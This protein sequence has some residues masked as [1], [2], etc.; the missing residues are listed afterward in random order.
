M[1]QMNQEKQ[2]ASS[3]RRNPKKFWQFVNRK[4]KM[5]QEV[6]D[7]EDPQSGEIVTSDVEKANILADYFTSVFTKEPPGNIP[8]ITQRSNELIDTV[9]IDEE[10][11]Y[12]KLQK[13]K[14]DKSPGPD[15]LHPRLLKELCFVISHPLS[16][17]FKN[18]FQCGEIPDD[19]KEAVVSAIFKKG[20]HKKPNNYRPVSLTS[21]VCKLMESI[22][23]DDIISYLKENKLF[24]EQQFGFIGGRSMVLQLLHVFDKWTG[25]IDRGGT[26]DCIYM[27]FQKAF[28]KVSHKRLLSKIESYGISGDLTRWIKAFLSGRSHRVRI[29]GCL[30]RAHNVTSG[31]PQ[32]SVLGPLLFVL[33]INDLSDNTDSKS[34]LF[35]DDTKIFWEISSEEDSIILQNDLTKLLEWSDRWLLKF[36][37]DKC[38]SL[39]IR[40]IYGSGRMSSRAIISITIFSFICIILLQLVLSL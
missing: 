25:I 35:A 36:H 16:M 24:S 33:Y 32:G 8:T 14:I 7:F 5:K 39:S 27:D 40:R 10:R 12:K 2:V 9:K 37:P 38:T 15:D 1:E 34:Y 28:D 23:W 6:A 29:N 18:S 31:I 20:E 3:S 19:W 4:T 13:L 17:I 21:I 11:V 30:S 26:I 22:V